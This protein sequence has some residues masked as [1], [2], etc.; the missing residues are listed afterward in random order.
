MT[1]KKNRTPEEEQ[2][3]KEF[4]EWIDRVIPYDIE[5]SKRM[6]IARC[7]ELNAEMQ[8]KKLK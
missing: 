8:Q 2:E 3:N 5:K 7:K 4:M 6:S 1:N